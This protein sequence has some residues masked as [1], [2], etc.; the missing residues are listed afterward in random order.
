MHDTS[1]FKLFLQLNLKIPNGIWNVLKQLVISPCFT[2]TVLNRE[3][4]LIRI[5]V[6]ILKNW[7]VEWLMANIQF[8][9]VNKS[10]LGK[11]QKKERLI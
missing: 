1:I 4:N 8:Q 6:I 3:I 10:S 11:G 7:N 5:T 2:F 9:S